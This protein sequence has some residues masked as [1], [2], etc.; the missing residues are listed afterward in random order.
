MKE[1]PGEWL[2]MGCDPQKRCLLESQD[3]CPASPT[4]H[5]GTYSLQL[6]GHSGIQLQV[7]DVFLDPVLT[8]VGTD[9]PAFFGPEAVER[10]RRV[11]HW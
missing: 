10:S 4:V 7:G 6:P 9:L 8:G 11:T 2:G 1:G 5:E 3:H